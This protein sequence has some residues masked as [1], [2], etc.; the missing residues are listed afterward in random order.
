MCTF[1]LLFD[2]DT[3]EFVRA[4]KIADVCRSMNGAKHFTSEW[5]AANWRSNHPDFGSFIVKRIQRY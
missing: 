5:S 4:G 1:Y 2:P 3:K